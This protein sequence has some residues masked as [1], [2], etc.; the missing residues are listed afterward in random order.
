MR[1]DPITFLAAGAL[2][3]VLPSP[4]AAEDAA[5]SQVD[6][7]VVE[8]GLDHLYARLADAEARQPDT[9]VRISVFADSI[10]GCDWVTS[11]L[12]HRLQARFGDGGRGWV[13]I[14]PGWTYQH[15][16]DV[17]WTHA[18]SWRTSILNRGD[19]PGARY[20]YGGVLAQNTSRGSKATFTTVPDGPS[21]TAVSRFRLFYQ[22]FPGGG[23][24]RVRVDGGEP[25]EVA[26]AAE[27]VE[28]RVHDVVVADGSHAFEVTVGQGHIR[29][30]GVVMER[31]GPG[32]VVES[33]ALIGAR[34]ARLLRF[35]REHL[36]R[37][38]E[39]RE[40][41]LLVFWLG[42]NNVLADRW[43]RDAFVRDYGQGI[44]AARQGRPEASCLVV[45][46][47]DI[48]ER[49]S[50]RSIERL[51]D[52][53]EA[54]REVARAQGCGFYDVFRAMGGAGTMRRWSF[55][56]EPRL[57][58]LDFRHITP[59]GGVHIGGLIH[60]A[61]IRGYEAFRNR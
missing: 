48:G 36:R 57:G 41:D 25:R 34:V 31:D 14:A 12:R 42:G 21:G 61:L 28:D 56:T 35:D 10:N 52:V 19:G 9:V 13:H 47:T 8:G 29:L 54:Q 60:D 59:E 44:A 24:V 4:G 5:P 16:Q 15:Q 18:Q 50:G 23:S 58:A 11:S 43:T 22:A 17:R 49:G 39:L 6:F 53:V 26:G 2:C 38:V 7:E 20:G 1:V 46:V 30:Y 45:S 3:V 32:V 55:S 51:P 37:Q 27:A 33:I 40:P